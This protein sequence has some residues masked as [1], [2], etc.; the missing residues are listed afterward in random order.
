MGRSMDQNATITKDLATNLQIAIVMKVKKQVRVHIRGIRRV[1]KAEN[2][3][4]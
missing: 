4:T 3:K 1:R 2:K